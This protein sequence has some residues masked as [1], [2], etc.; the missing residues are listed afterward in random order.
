MAL[1]QQIDVYLIVDIINH[2]RDLD[3]FGTLK[4]LFNIIGV[5]TAEFHL[6]RNSSYWDVFL[7][8]FNSFQRSEIIFCFNSDSGKT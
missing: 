6:I 4:Y 7:T 2:W 1:G 5:E 3:I 8:R